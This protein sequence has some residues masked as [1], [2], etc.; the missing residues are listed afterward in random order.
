[1]KSRLFLLSLPMDVSHIL[2]PLDFRS[3]V[4]AKISRLEIFT[5]KFSLDFISACLFMSIGGTKLD[6]G[7]YFLLSSNLPSDPITN[8]TALPREYCSKLRGSV[9]PPKGLFGLLADFVNRKPFVMFFSTRYPV[10][11]G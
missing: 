8:R 4:K 10:S 7:C 3:I 9:S 6:K 2:T 1:M 5:T 11:F